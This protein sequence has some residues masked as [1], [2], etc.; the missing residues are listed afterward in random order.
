M[1]PIA[2]VAFTIISSTILTSPVN[3]QTDDWSLRQIHVKDRQKMEDVVAEFNRRATTHEIGKTQPPLTSMEIVAAIRTSMV[4]HKIPEVQK[5]QFERIAE[6]RIIGPAKRRDVILYF[7]SEHKLNGYHFTH[8]SIYLLHD[9]IT[10]PIRI[11]NLDSRHLTAEEKKVLADQ[12]RRI[13][14]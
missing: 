6:T 9:G 2:L 3:A 4:N 8:W 1:R 14:R 7:S 12:V 13:D 11:R 10:I 5:A